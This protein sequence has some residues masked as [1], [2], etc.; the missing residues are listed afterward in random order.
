MYSKYQLS[1]P[2]SA[3]AT[4]TIT[5]EVAEFKE[6]ARHLSELKHTWPVCDLFRQ[7]EEVV[8]AA[9]AKFESTPKGE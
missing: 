9:S 8:R 3:R 1:V 7:I 2:E 4:I 5:A 6:L